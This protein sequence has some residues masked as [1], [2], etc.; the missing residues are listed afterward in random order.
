MDDS[1]SETEWRPICEDPAL[2]E[3]V[4]S[5]VFDIADVL[6]K[7]SYDGDPTLLGAGGTAV[8]FTYLDSA[9]PGRG[10]DAPIDG[11]LETATREVSR[12]NLTQ[13]LYAG[14]SGL[15]WSIEHICPTEDEADVDPNAGI[16]EALALLLR[17]SP[18]PGHF[19]LIEG[20]V[21]VGV[22]ALERTPRPT[23]MACLRQIL[24]RLA[25]TATERGDGITWWTNPHFL[26]PDM[27]RYPDGYHNL[28]VAHGIAGVIAFLARACAFAE[29]EPAARPLL[30]RA[31]AYLL[32]FRLPPGS[33]GNFSAFEE[34]RFPARAA[35][36]YGDPGIATA[37]LGAA[38]ATGR[39]DWERVAVD[40]A[41]DAARRPFADTRVVDASLCHGTAGLA[42]LFNRMY[43]AT[44]E[45]RLGEA[46]TDWVRHTI[47]MRGAP[48]EAA[49]FLFYGMDDDGGDDWAP[50]RRFPDGVVGVG[51]ALLGCISDVAPDWDRVLLCSLPAASGARSM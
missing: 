32:G 35:W 22:Y 24:D 19:D 42:H 34:E 26:G 28:G 20:L 25:E 9:F 29:L 50:K 6:A 48:N 39:A 38:R 7:D 2:A 10:F 17:Q 21:G 15:A 36:C 43:H 45:P 14:F 5:T 51:L 46:A 41:L 11:L 44:G 47:E 49:G 4:R 40:I 16:D 18:W 27:E 1:V 37:L 8:F 33:G 23:S 31:V 12:G 3:K 13:G 30:E